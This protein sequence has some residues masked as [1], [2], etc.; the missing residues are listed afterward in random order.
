MIG[1]LSKVSPLTGLLPSAQSCSVK[2]EEQCK[3]GRAVNQ[4]FDLNGFQ[5]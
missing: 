1:P 2:W 5:V 4:G 3:M